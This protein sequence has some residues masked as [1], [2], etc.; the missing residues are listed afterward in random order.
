M[1]ATCSESK[2]FENK[3][4]C[5]RTEPRALSHEMPPLDLDRW[6][7]F[8][9]QKQHASIGDENKTKAAVRVH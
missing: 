7:H 5:R 9:K 4:V 2:L 8:F 6:Q 3:Y 1:W